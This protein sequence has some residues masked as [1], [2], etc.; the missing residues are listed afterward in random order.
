[1]IHATPNNIEEL[2]KKANNKK[3]WRERLEAV[4]QLKNYDCQKSRDII[5]RLAIN[6]K[7]FK[8]KEAAFRAAQSLDIQKNGRPI[9][10]NK[11]KKGE[12]DKKIQTKLIKVKG[13]LNTGY[14]HEDFKNKFNSL[15]PETYDL[16]EGNKNNFDDWLKNRE[17]ILPKQK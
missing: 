7:V 13:S 17:S 4:E 12:L 16:Y 1:M 5:G 15:Y 9:S 14:S 8:V 6:D 10:L 11:K 3:S 2:K